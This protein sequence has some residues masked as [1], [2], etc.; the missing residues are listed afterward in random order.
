MLNISA[1]E[2]INIDILLQKLEELNINNLET[3]NRSFLRTELHKN[4]FSIQKSSANYWDVEGPEVDRITG[5]LGNEN[6]VFNEC[7][8]PDTDNDGTPNHLDLDSDGDGCSDAVEA[9]T[10]TSLTATTVSGGFGTN[11]FADNLETSGNG[12]YIIN[13]GNFQ[14][15][16]ASVSYYD[17]D[18][19]TLKED[20]YKTANSIAL[21]DVAQSMAVLNNKAYIV[22]NNSSKIEVVNAQTF[23]SVA[24]IAGLPSPRY[25]LAVNN[26]KAYVSDYKANAISI[27][28]LNTN[29]KTGSIPCTGFTEEMAMAHGKVFVTNAFRDKVYVIN[30][31]TDLITDSITV[32]YGSSSIQQDKNGK[33][34]VLCVGDQT[35]IIDATLYRIN[36][37]NNSV[38]MYFT[39]PVAEYPSKLKMNG[40][41]DTM[42]FLNSGVY[43]MPISASSL[44]SS[45]FITQ[46]SKSFYALGVDPASGVIYVADA[47]DYVQ[48]SSV[49]R[50][51]SQ[52][53]L[54]NTFKA[55]IITGDFVW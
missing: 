51:T 27:V 28:D 46:G 42:Y 1:L 43:Q 17:V 44:P 48:K 50:Y 34:W 32:G 52:G 6:D 18:T 29:T 16:N 25:F 38:E 54:L 45:P 39:F 26:A 12:V 24:T 20:I 53:V 10:V 7:D 41:N 40:T 4:N 21:G 49:Y 22:V 47:I 2:E 19:K 8:S 35:N 55:G 37:L 31:S 3:L 11:G 13:E 15:G 9:K 36:P 23:V 5:L 14:F 33:L 30:S